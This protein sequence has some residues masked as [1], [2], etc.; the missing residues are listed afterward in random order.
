MVQQ[1]Y[2]L[3]DLN[4]KE[5]L[6][7]IDKVTR[8]RNP[9][10]KYLERAK[11][12]GSTAKYM[13]TGFNPITDYVKEGTPDKEYRELASAPVEEEVFELVHR[14]THDVLGKEIFELALDPRRQNELVVEKLGNMAVNF[15]RKRFYDLQSLMSNTN[16]SDNKC[17]YRK[18][19]ILEW[20]EADFEKAEQDAIA[21]KIDELIG[22]CTDGI[23]NTKGKNDAYCEEKDVLLFVNRRMGTKTHLALNNKLI[24]DKLSLSAR[25]LDIISAPRLD[26]DVLAVACSRY[27]IR[28]D[29]CIDMIVKDP[30]RGDTLKQVIWKHV[31]EHTNL[32]AKNPLVCLKLKK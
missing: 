8:Y 6:V 2:I 13:V 16:V 14:K 9:V 10:D 32:S 25:L 31:Y 3:E 11:I 1:N 29:F 19:Q 28:S 5:T 12:E 22:N 20:K 23:N 26:N 7:K 30:M 18:E 27:A 21:E 4:N 17:P 15:S 24:A